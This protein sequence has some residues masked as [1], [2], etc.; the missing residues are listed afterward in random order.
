MF[1]ALS[2]ALAVVESSLPKKVEKLRTGA[3]AVCDTP[4]ASVRKIQMFTRSAAAARRQNLPRQWDPSW[5]I[6]PWDGSHRKWR[7]SAGD[8]VARDAFVAAS[9]KLI[10]SILEWSQRG[11]P[12]ES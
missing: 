12:N 1:P 8:V 6:N 4:H 2:R 9:N 10:R 5:N 7:A 3:L 11:A